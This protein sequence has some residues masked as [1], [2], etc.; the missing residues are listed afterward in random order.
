MLWV[1]GVFSRASGAL[2]KDVSHYGGILVSPV[3]LFLRAKGQKEDSTSKLS[4]RASLRP[5]FLTEVFPN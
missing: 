2:A 5:N 4:L 1:D 3:L